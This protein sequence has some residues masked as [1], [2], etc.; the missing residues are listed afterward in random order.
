MR[1]IQPAEDIQKS[2]DKNKNLP[3]RF[4]INNAL[5]DVTYFLQTKLGDMDEKELHF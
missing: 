2:I 5:V 3:K 4:R 1:Q